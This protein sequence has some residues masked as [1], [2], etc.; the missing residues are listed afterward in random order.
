MVVQPLT[1]QREPCL[2][3]RRLGAEQQP[4]PSSAARLRPGRGEASLFGRCGN[5]VQQP[6]G[7]G[8]SGS[9][10]IPIA[11]TCVGYPD[12]RLRRS[13]RSESDAPHPAGQMGAPPIP[14]RIGNCGYPTGPGRPGPTPHDRIFTPPCRYGVG[15][16]LLP[17]GRCPTRR[18]AEAF[19]AFHPAGKIDS[20]MTV[21][22]QPC[23]RSSWKKS[24]TICNSPEATTVS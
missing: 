20:S 12:A 19:L 4:G 21:S 18:L 16:D 10:S 23:R 1:D 9:A 22:A 8:A 24:S 14:G 11:E 17:S 15:D 2:V 3:D 5:Q 6:S 7:S 13:R